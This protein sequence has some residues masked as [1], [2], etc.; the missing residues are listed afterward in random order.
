M[1]RVFEMA[2]GVVAWRITAHAGMRCALTWNQEIAPS[3][4]RGSDNLGP[5][6]DKN[7]A[8]ELLAI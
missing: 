8:H 4:A 3:Q 2:A 6:F 1:Y 7:G 5:G